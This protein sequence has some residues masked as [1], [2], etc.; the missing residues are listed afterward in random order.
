[1][2]DEKSEMIPIANE[3]GEIKAI[4]IV[5][6]IGGLTLIHFDVKDNDE[7]A[8]EIA[9]REFIRIMEEQGAY[10]ASLT[11]PEKMRAYGHDFD[12]LA[13]VY[14]ISTNYMSEL[15]RRLRLIGE[16]SDHNV[17]PYCQCSAMV[18]DSEFEGCVVPYLY[19]LIKEGMERIEREISEWNKCVRCSKAPCEK[20]F[21]PEASTSDC[22]DFVKRISK[23][24][25]SP[26]CWAN[27]SD[28]HI[29]MA[30]EFHKKEGFSKEEEE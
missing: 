26:C 1:M 30:L 3:E 9:K 10:L 12:S 19:C 22:S 13:D 14:E 27:P 11:F 4:K 6:K 29:D 7:E 15:A 5:E 21:D 23:Y 25:H 17:H 2:S 24:L 18:W 8:S 20:Y 28:E 16:W